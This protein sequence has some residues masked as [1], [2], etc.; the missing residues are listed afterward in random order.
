[1]TTSSKDIHPAIRTFTI[2]FRKRKTDASSIKAWIAKRKETRRPNSIRKWL[3]AEIM[4]CENALSDLKPIKTHPNVELARQNAR[5]HLE[6]ASMAKTELLRLHPTARS[7]YRPRRSGR[8]PNRLRVGLLQRERDIF[9][10]SA[11]KG[12]PK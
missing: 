8:R 1:M 11:Q 4:K 3:N 7:Q 5:A 12:G 6:W 2:G 9:N 10:G